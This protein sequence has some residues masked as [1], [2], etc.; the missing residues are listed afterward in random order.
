LGWLPGSA[1]SQL[2]HSCSL[3]EHGRME[4]VLDSS[5]TTKNMSV[6][7]ILLILNPKHSSCQ[8]DN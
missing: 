2:L 8:E 6:T 5:A 3:V 1:P 4:K 7:N